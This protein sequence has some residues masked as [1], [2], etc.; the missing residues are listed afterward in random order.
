MEGPAWGETP[1]PA[2]PI[3]VKNRSGGKR[4]W[5]DID[6]GMLAAF[7]KALG[8][9]AFESDGK[10]LFPS[11]W[12]RIGD[13][14]CDDWD[15]CERIKLGDDAFMILTGLVLYILKTTQKMDIDSDIISAPLRYCLA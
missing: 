7:R 11:L 14:I 15:F 9:T 4:R 6:Q 2:N 1:K 8:S 12:S 3:R 5:R 10:D 13:T